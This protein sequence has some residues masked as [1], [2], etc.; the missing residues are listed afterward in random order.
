MSALLKSAGLLLVAVVLFTSIAHAQYHYSIAG[1]I[2]DD[3]GRGIDDTAISAR[4]AADST[5]VKI[6]LCDHD[7]RYAIEFTAGQ[8]ALLTASAIGFTDVSI[9]VSP[10]D[11]IVDII[12][13]SKSAELNS[14]IVTAKTKPLIERKVDRTVFNVASSISAAGGNAYDAIKKAPAVIV[15]EG[16]NSITIAG[17][18]TAQVMLN[19]RLLQLSA[20]DLTA[21]LQAIPAD[22]IDR[23]EVITAPPAQYDALGN[24]GL[25]NIVLKKNRSTGYNSTMRLGYEQ[26]TYGTGVGGATMNY[27]KG[28]INF[29]GTINYANGA[30]HNTERLNTYLP[31]QEYRLIDPYKKEI[32]NL[33]YTAGADYELNKSQVLGV[34]FNSTLFDRTDAGNTDV[35]I[36]QRNTGTVDSVGRTINHNDANRRTDIL[37][38]NY[39]RTIDST[40][41]KL[42]LNANRLWYNND[43][44]RDFN[45]TN[46]QGLFGAPTGFA[47]HDQNAG[48]QQVTI[49][50][51]QADVELPYHW[52]SLNLG[53]KVSFV[54]NYSS[55]DF[56]SLM[57]GVWV[58]NPSISNAFRYKEAVQAAYISAQKE[59]PKWSFQAGLRVEATQVKGYS[60][61]LNQTNASAYLN[62]FPT[63]YITYKPSEAHVL[64]LT[65]NKRIN[66]PG[67]SELNPFRVYSSPY[68]YSE[69]NPY[70]GP[71]YDHTIGLDYTLHQKVTFSAYYEHELSHFGLLFG[72]DSQTHSSYTS[73]AN[74][75]TFT[76]YGISASASFSPAAWW[77]VQAF[78]TGGI[79]E[80]RTHASINTQEQFYGQPATYISVSNSFVLNKKKTLLA[81]V[82]AYYI[83]KQQQDLFVVNHSG[84]VDT[85]IKALL[86]DKKLVVSLGATDIFATQRSRSVNQAT[87][88][89][90]NSYFDQRN[91]RLMLNYKLGSDKIKA[92]RERATG[93]EDESKRT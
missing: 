39:V 81:E 52:A 43:R 18:S 74:F 47:E 19:G 83:S 8:T 60:P 3:G 70:L 57:N 29:Y 58:N 2:I 5:V 51:A 66:R 45:T 16:D 92:R 6:A 36:A 62:L 55:N 21:Y 12:L 86:L 63:A 25:I 28:K 9:P 69:G 76:A 11:T 68:L 78:A 56:R 90:L 65:Y 30:K 31:D 13:H 32:S 61:T 93:V 20:E 10:T 54:D 64:S 35:F 27:R 73:I 71:S 53:G 41:K 4:L 75:G 15:K 23:I 72:V 85:A 82:N 24:S 34:Q 22:N 87:G 46:Y 59:L 91:L 48:V 67:Y 50:T 33:Q 88:Q 40:G 17:K 79:Q 42:T 89:T 7:G 26:S 84:S 14:V 80:I 38:L 44:V 1:R 77:E 37:N 49:T